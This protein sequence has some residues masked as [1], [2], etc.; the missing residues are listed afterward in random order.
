MSIAFRIATGAD[1]PILAGVIERAYAGWVP[2]LGGRRPRPMDDDHAARTARGENWLAYEADE[3]VV[4]MIALVERDDALHIFNI[5]VDPATQGRGL[6]RLLLGFAELRAR[7]L[8]LTR[9]TLFT[10]VEMA[11]NVEIYRHLGFAERRR[12]MAAGG[13]EIVFMERDVPPLP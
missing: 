13:Y 3:S 12:E 10:N 8:G 2:E 9:L 1:I 5:A 7:E 4:G 11:R 6:L